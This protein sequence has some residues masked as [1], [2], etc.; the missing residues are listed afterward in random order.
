MNE[1][2]NNRYASKEFAYGIKPNQFFK[3]QIQKINPGKI[4]FPA[5]GE[6]RNAVYAATLGFEVYAFDPS[7]EGKKKA[8]QLADQHKVNIDYRTESYESISS[9]KDFFDGI[10]LI[11]AHMPAA[12]RQKYH[13]KLL[14]FL[15][16]GG[17]IILEGFSKAQIE[18]DTGGPKD[19][20]MLFSEDE[21]RS[22]FESFSEVE[23]NKTE[24]NL[25]EGPYHQGIASVIQLVGKK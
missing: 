3:E 21:L 16:P 5:E 25:N 10:V 9:E 15:K 8:L 17:I 4:L 14:T 18:R 20:T 22:D 23:I 1:F 12:V 6:G 7:F 13:Q 24:V 19:I 2:W 11:F